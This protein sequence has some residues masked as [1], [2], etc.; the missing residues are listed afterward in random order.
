MARETSSKQRI[1]KFLLENIGRVIDAKELQEASGWKAEWGRRV[2]ELRDEDGYQILSHKDRADLKPGQ[3]LIETAKRRPAFRRGI[4]KE[5]RALVLERNGFTCQMCGLAAGD[6]DPLNPA[7][8]VRLTMG[9]IKDKSKGGVDSI[10]NL[11]AV[12]TNCNEGLQ[13]AALPKPDRV[14]LLA[15]VR[16]ATIDDQKAVLD[17]LTQKFASKER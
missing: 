5:T 3:Y 10:D 14:W 2:R 8:T 17:W 16:R 1:L 12:C 11:R 7:R 15:Q 4:S 6:P 9:H 13:N